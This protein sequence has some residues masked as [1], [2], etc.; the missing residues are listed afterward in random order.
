M[1]FLYRILTILLY[2]IFVLVIYLRR[3]FNKEDKIRFIEKISINENNLPK[4]KKIIWMHAASIGK[5]QYN[6]THRKYIKKK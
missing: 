1:F 6:A 2:P 4:N 5:Q 3:F